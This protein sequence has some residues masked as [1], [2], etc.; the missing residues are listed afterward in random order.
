MP[1][2]RHERPR[3]QHGLRAVAAV[4]AMAILPVSGLIRPPAA[5][6]VT[7]DQLRITNVTDPV[8]RGASASFTVQLVQPD[9]SLDT[10]YRG[11]IH[12]TSSDPA[13]QLPPD[14]TFQ[15][16]DNGQ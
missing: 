11:R 9:A 15:A 14:Y 3:R 5:A 16:S 4:L 7:I 12:V 8:V 13:A 2:T 10:G 6:A 1:T